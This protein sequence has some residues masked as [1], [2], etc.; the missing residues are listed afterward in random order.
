MCGLRNRDSLHFTLMA[1]YKLRY[2]RISNSFQSFVHSLIHVL[3]NL[4]KQ[5]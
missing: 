2:V 1:S 4:P 5:P 3:T